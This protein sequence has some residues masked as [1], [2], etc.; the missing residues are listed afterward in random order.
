MLDHI[1]IAVTDFGRSKN[2]YV[3]ALSPLGIDV[4]M[5]VTAEQTGSTP[6][7]GLG[8]DG[9]PY[10]WI[11]PG[12]VAHNHV[13]FTAATRADVDSFYKSA[14]AAGGRD[15][16]APGLRPHYHPDYYGAFVLDPDGHNI[17]AVCHRPE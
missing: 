4:V 12:A 16:G 10:F 15:N 3:H 17:E 9:K 14:L 2:F 13:A 11:S 8:S 1:G 5:E 7:C 6:S